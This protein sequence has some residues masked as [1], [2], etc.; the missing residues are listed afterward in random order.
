MANMEVDVEIQRR[1]VGERRSRR[2]VRLNRTVRERQDQCI[3]TVK[4]D[5]DIMGR[6]EGDDKVNKVDSTH[7]KAYVFVGFK[8]KTNS[9]AA[10]ECTRDV[11]IDGINS[12][13]SIGIV[14]AIELSK[15][16]GSFICIEFI[17]IDSLHRISTE[18]LIQLI[19]TIDLSSEHRIAA[20]V[21]VPGL[22][23]DL[24]T[25]ALDAG[26]SGTVF[27]HINTLE[28]AAVVVLK[29]CYA[30]SGGKRSLSP[31]ALIV[32]VT[33]IA[34]LR[35]SHEKVANANVAVYENSQQLAVKN[36]EIAATSGLNGLTFGP[37][38]LRISLGLPSKQ[39]EEFDDPGVPEAIARLIAVSEK[40]RKP[41]MI[42]AFKV[43]AKSSRWID[44]SRILITSADLYSVTKGH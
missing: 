38:D 25:F 24:V 36:I 18:N 11:I 22:Y 21:R 44:K 29:C 12:A 35:T 23:S 28:E 17:F 26:A 30:Y 42:V 5:F 43:P 31:S 1:G 19:Q 9:D 8:R 39:V 16:L 40:Y 33:D 6:K 20:I 2:S 32:G 27:P 4:D 41:L 37:K 14:I 13:T 7:P 15:I 10:S 3:W 34:L